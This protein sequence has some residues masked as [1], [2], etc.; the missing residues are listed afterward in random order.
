MLCLEL[1]VLKFLIVPI[2]ISVHNILCYRINFS[3]GN[4]TFQTFCIVISKLS[5]I[6]DQLMPRRYHTHRL[7]D[8]TLLTKFFFLLTDNIAHL[9]ATLILATI[10]FALEK[11]SSVYKHNL[12]VEQY[13]FCVQSNYLYFN[14]ELI[15]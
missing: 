9:H 11:A 3:I 5:T 13:V 4:F 1:Y 12:P 7:N 10:T 15:Q 8:L 14:I 2:K 6:V